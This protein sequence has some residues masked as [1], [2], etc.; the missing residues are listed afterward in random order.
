MGKKLFCIVKFYLVASFILIIFTPQVGAVQSHGGAEG[1]V[2]HQIGHLFFIIGTVSLIYQ[3]YKHR[4]EGPG[5]SSFKRFL[6]LI[7]LWNCLTFSGHYLREAIA[8]KQFNLIDGKV[9]SFHISTISDMIFYLSR[10]DH[11]VLLPALLF[12]VLA[13]I[14]WKRA[15]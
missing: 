14:Q 2:S 8:P 4:A 1:L 6:W 15:S 10:L 9:E 5:W 11:L 13:I 7:L 3:I 12:L